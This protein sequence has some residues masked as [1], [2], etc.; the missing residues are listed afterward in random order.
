MLGLVY[1]G[2]G[3]VL[4]LGVEEQPMHEPAYKTTPDQKPGGLKSRG[5]SEK[6][7]KLPKHPGNK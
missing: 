3:G 7:S 2:G 5:R 6:G 4:G 1:P